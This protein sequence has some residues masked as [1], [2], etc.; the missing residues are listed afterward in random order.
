[1]RYPNVYG[2]DMPTRAELIATGRTGEEIGIEIGAD[3][4]VYQDL[5]ALKA[6]VRDLKPAL[7]HF[8]TSCFDGAYVT[9]DV[10]PEY[11][12]AIEMAREGHRTTTKEER[13]AS[14][15]LQLNLMSAG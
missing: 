8:D 3:A 11:L 13:R 6:S 5:E 10:S 1:V 12:L 9:G 2:I 14:R 15:Q 7:C 4:L